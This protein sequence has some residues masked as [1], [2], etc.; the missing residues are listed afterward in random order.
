VLQDT[1]K[2]PVDLIVPIV[3]K[4][5]QPNSRDDVLVTLA[6]LVNADSLMLLHN[7]IKQDASRLN[8]LSEQRLRRRVQKLA[9]AA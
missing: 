7:L 5:I 9:S 6:T 8:K 3:S 2:P 1:L 4:I